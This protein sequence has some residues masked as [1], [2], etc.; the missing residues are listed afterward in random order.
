VKEAERLLRGA[1]DIEPGRVDAS[2]AMS[3]LLVETFRVEE[4]LSLLRKLD[5]AHPPPGDA[6]ILSQLCFTQ[7]YAWDM[8]ADETVEAARRYGR[9]VARATPPLPRVM[10]GAGD[11]DRRLR[12]GYLSPDL[13]EHSVSFFLE[14]VLRGH[15]R[16]GFEVFVYHTGGHADAM[17]ERLRGLCGA[18]WRHAYMVKDEP[19]AE[20]IRKDR[21][22]I[23]VELAGHSSQQR[24]ALMQRRPAPVQ[25]SY[26]GYAATTGVPE[27][28][29]RIVDAVTD[30]PGSERL[31]VERLERVDGCF[32]CYQP[33]LDAPERT[34]GGGGS[35]VTFGSFNVISKLSDP[36]IEVWS[37][38]LKAVPGSRLVLKSKAIEQPETRARILERFGRAGIEAERS[39]VPGADGERTGP[40]GRVWKDGCGPRSVSVQRNH[41]DMRG[42]VDGG[43]VVTLAG[44]RHV[45]RVGASLLT[46]AGFGDWSRRRRRST[47]RWRLGWRVMRRGGQ[48]CI[49][50][51]GSGCRPRGCAT[52][53][54]T[55]G[56]WKRRIGGCGIAGARQEGSSM[57]GVDPMPQAMALVQ[58]GRFEQAVAQLRRQIQK[59][60]ND[61][62]ALHAL[63]A[64]FLHLGEFTQAEFFLSRAV[65]LWPGCRRITTTWRTRCIRSIAWK[66]PWCITE[67]RSTAIRRISRRTSGWRRR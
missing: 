44:D 16:S 64:V 23:L 56:L 33:P 67:S 43:A 4:A 10:P 36:T 51:S 25:A 42:A 63:G 50:R 53:R 29:Y 34:P 66:T 20:L 48:N 5:T 19:L 58:A 52:V 45:A 6:E 12:V 11:R 8:R 14:P 28:H 15:D 47:W 62:A 60:P 37:R 57:K 59:Q 49:G 31:S 46:A 13:R 26:I 2:L 35:P 30:P 1:L 24:L 7:N 32:L 54:R 27:I 38:I 18:G 9:A 40:L 55:R 41:D 21:I 22:D 61:P 65:T 39:R 3:R 17:T